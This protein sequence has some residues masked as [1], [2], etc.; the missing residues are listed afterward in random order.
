MKAKFIILAL[1][2]I[3]TGI[4]HGDITVNIYSGHSTTGGGTPY[5]GLVGTFDSPDIQFATNTGYAWHPFGLADFGA[6]MTGCLDV[7]SEGT[8]DFSLDS[9]DGSLLFID[10][11]LVVNNGGPHSPNT[12]SG[13]VFLTAGLHPFEVQFFEDYGGPS[14]VDLTLPRGV[15][16]GECPVPVPGAVLLGVLGLCTAGVKLRKRA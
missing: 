2:L 16:Y 14:G 15:I 13:S 10:S 1:A 11:G 5:S 7:A 4:A 3:I 12:A 8:Y 9:D 6:Q